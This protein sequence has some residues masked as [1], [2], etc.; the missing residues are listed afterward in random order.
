M[1]SELELLTMAI[2]I[3]LVHLAWAA[4]AARRQQG[5]NWA[6]GPRDE[7][8]PVTGVAARL[9][10]AFNNFRE[11]FP[12]FGVAVLAAYLTGKTGGGLCLWGSVLYV[13]GRA[14]Y[15]PLYAAGIRSW[16]SLVWFISFIGLVM[17]ATSLVL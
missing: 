4:I 5:L 12:F 15:L 11:T 6:R 16:R 2:G 10:R 3:G 13:A 8:R 14:A 9:E 1:V 7:P 17:V